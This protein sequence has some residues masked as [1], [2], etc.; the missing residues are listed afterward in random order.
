MVI[1]WQQ[2]GMHKQQFEATGVVASFPQ[3]S[4]REGSDSY[5]DPAL[6]SS[7]STVSS[8]FWGATGLST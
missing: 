1:H 4:V 5:C 6:A 3:H 7:L 2:Q 8:S